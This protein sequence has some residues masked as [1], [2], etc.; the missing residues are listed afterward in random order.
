[1]IRQVDP[2]DGSSIE[3]NAGEPFEIV[4]PENPTTGYVWHVDERHA[5]ED[6][7]EPAFEP[8]GSAVGAGGFRTFR[9]RAPTSGQSTLALTLKRPGGAS[10]ADARR[11]SIAVRKSGD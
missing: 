1:M 9:L 11:I 3:V 5:L 6:A 7:G 10:T 4:L 8:A 2:A